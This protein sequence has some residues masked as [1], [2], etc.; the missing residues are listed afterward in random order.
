M[1][2]EKEEL[3]VY[4]IIRLMDEAVLSGLFGVLFDFIDEQELSWAHGAIRKW[5]DHSAAL[6]FD[7]HQSE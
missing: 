3:E 2:I 1:R 4:I 6:Q 7:R 5:G